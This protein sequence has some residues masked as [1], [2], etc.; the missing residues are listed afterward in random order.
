LDISG[1]DD[2]YNSVAILLA[3]VGSFI[4]I[5]GSTGIFGVCCASKFLGRVL[6]I[7]VRKCLV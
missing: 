1:S 7:L 5:V 3:I 2:R 6:L 4:L